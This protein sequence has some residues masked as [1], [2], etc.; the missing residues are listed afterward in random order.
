VE[1]QRPTRKQLIELAKHDP[2]AIADLV[3][4]LWDRVEKLEAKVA[5]LEL[6]SRNSS[7]P[8]SSDGGNFTNPPKP[9]SLRRK[10][11]RKPGGQKGHQGK[12]LS[13]VE[14][15]DH[16]VEHRFEASED[17]PKCGHAIGVQANAEVPSTADWE[18]R[19]IFELPPIRVEV[20]EHRAQRCV[21]K[22]CG[23]KLVADF[24]V[25]VNAP[26]QYGPNLK[27]TALY[28]GGYQ[29]IPYNR[30]SELFSELFRCPL[31]QGT[32]ANFVKSGGKK[33][34]PVVSAIRKAL[35]KAKVLHVDETGCRLHG[36]RHWLHVAS[37]KRL[38]F[39]HFDAK[40]G[41]QAMVNMG[42][43]HNYRGGL[44]HD[45][46]QAYYAFTEC[47]HF[48]CNAHL[49]RE[50]T[51]IYEQIGQSWAKDMIELLL[52][53]KQLRDREDRRQSGKRRVIG[54]ATRKRIQDRYFEIVLAGYAINP[55]P[56]APPPDAKGKRK[57]GRVARG[58]A[59]NLLDRFDRRYPQ[60]MG[61]F[62]FEGV[63]FDNNQAERDLRMMKIREK[64]SG[65]FRSGEHARAFCDLRSI[66]SSA[67]KQGIAIV[68]SL[69]ALVKSP[70]ALADSLVRS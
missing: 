59:L 66:I 22:G 53:A 25:E 36:K 17:C 2:A 13:Q 28:L 44:V 58:K 1:G 70:D 12:T 69:N 68:D 33:A 45:F 39:L 61:F 43:L 38:T 9:K 62:E 50:L 21:C 29:L 31:S 56:E 63:P 24:P 23:T 34:R 8:P 5:S 19:Q 27:A 57:R 52:E 26:T 7:K 60:I 65:T 10:S 20:T 46:W 15:A 67:R 47:L 30:L 32:L 64:V 11:G 14:N 54:D 41:T 35:V 55:E 18:R 16:I 51:Y 4:S 6:N 3:L 49:L 42:L 37:T 48:L 40:R